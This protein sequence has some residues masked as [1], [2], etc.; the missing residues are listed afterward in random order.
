LAGRLISK[1]HGFPFFFI[2]RVADQFKRDAKK[3]AE[4]FAHPRS[5]IDTALSYALSFPTEIQTAIGDYEILNDFERLRETLPGIE[6]I[7]V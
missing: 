6:L 7:K 5:L 1:G 4:H 2:V 3:T